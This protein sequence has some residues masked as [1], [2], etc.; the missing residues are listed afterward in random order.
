MESPKDD[1]ERSETD[2]QL[3]DDADESVTSANG[4]KKSV[5]QGENH[6]E[7]RLVETAGPFEQYFVDTN[8]VS[9]N[10]RLPYIMMMFGALGF[11]VDEIYPYSEIL[12]DA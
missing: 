10:K 12:K 7:L 4:E 9:E 3:H 6:L 8:N 1:D 11:I 5:S 2:L